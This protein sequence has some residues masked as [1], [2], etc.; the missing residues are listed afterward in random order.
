MKELTDKDYASF[1]ADAPLPVIIDVWA[2]W[3]GPCKFLTPVLQEIADEYGD[4]VIVAKL[5]IDEYPEVA[6][7]Y[8][9]TNIPTL[10]IYKDGKM[11]KMIIGAHDKPVLVSKLEKFLK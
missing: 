5:N 11:A 10:L 3:C 1:I 9:V 8:G 6:K 4:K 2:D 7:E